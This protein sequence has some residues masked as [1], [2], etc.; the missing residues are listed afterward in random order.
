MKLTSLFFLFFAWFSSNSQDTLSIFFEFGESKITKESREIISSISEEFETTTLDSL[1]FIGYADSVGTFSNNLKLSKKRADKVSALTLSFL[2]ENMIY[3]IRAK[4]EK[5]KNEL[6]FNRSVDLIF[7]YPPFQNLEIIVDKDSLGK[8][9]YQVDFKLL[10]QCNVVFRKRGKRKFVNI[11]LND[12][13]ILSSED[14]YYAHLKPDQS[15]VLK[16]VKWKRK[17]IGKKHWAKR[18]LFLSI[19]E[20][21]F[22]SKY[23]FHLKNE[24]C[25]SC[26]L[27]WSEKS[28]KV[29]KAQCLQIDRYIKD[30][31]QLRNIWLQPKKVKIRVPKI[32]VDTSSTYYVGCNMESELKW[33]TKRRSKD[34][35]FAKLPVQNSLIRMVTRS[36]DCCENDPLINDCNYFSTFCDYDC[37]IRDSLLN[38]VSELGIELA[39]E[40]PSAY[41]LIGFREM[42]NFNRFDFFTGLD[43]KLRLIN[44]LSY[45]R[46]LYRSPL[47][48]LNPKQNWDQMEGLTKKRND[49]DF[50]LYIGSDIRSKL[51]GL[52]ENR[53]DHNIHLG[54][55][56]ANERLRQN[57]TRY[58]V[59]FGYGINYLEQEGPKLFFSARLGMNIRLLR[60]KTSLIPNSPVY[61][62]PLK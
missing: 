37:L 14:L 5:F 24:P 52:S 55:A 50:N 3:S 25:D 59:H 34:Y 28:T 31:A 40:S 60:L 23:L 10:S 49:W 21:D 8:M 42:N 32:F 58:F 54:I 19:P 44:S 53:I 38:L 45:Q 27:H 22:T 12:P 7:Y 17:K 57:L 48:L 47:V 16:Q 13:E 18:Q 11:S 6:S 41:I 15:V 20:E 51:F 29:S 4:G 39:E 35:Y 56:M 33:K 36:K 9:C 46:L 1:V 26:D 2:D 61:S 62:I 43:S 30:N